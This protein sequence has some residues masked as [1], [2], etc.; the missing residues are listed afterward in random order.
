MESLTEFL[1]MDR[2]GAYVWPSY[3]LAT[4]IMSGLWLST[5]ARLKRNETELRQLEHST[6]DQA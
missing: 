5:R 4:L 3:L 1:A 2:Y 6:E